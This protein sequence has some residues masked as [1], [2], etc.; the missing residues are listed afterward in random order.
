[1][2]SDRE[3]VD[4]KD[5]YGKTPCY[6]TAYKGQKL[7]MELLLQ[8][9]ASHGADVNLQDNWG[10]TPMYLAACSGQIECIRLLVQAGA[11]ITYKN[12]RDCRFGQCT[13]QR[14]MTD[15]EQRFLSSHPLMPLLYLRYIDDIFI[16]WT[17][18]KEALEE[19]HHDFNNFHPAINLNLDSNEKRLSLN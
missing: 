12:K 7:S 1:M 5:Y 3:L 9:G 16:I 17:H 19:F 8:H 11:D 6:W 15:L 10:V 14:G 13:W 4:R 18:G 2:T